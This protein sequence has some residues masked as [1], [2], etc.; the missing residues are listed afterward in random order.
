MKFRMVYPLLEQRFHALL[1]RRFFLGLPPVI[2]RHVYEAG[3]IVANGI[4]LLE[5]VL[6]FLV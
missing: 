2:K 6:R 3:T 1:L 5:I 4:V